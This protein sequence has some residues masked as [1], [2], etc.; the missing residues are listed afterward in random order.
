MNLNDYIKIVELTERIEKSER[1]LNFII[2]HPFRFLARSIFYPLINIKK[3]I[4]NLKNR[5]DIY[6]RTR[7]MPVTEKYETKNFFSIESI[8]DRIYK[9]EI[10]NNGQEVENFKVEFKT[11]NK[12][13]IFVHAYYEDEAVEII[14]NISKFIDYDIVVST[15]FDSIAELFERNMDNDRL[16]VVKFPNHGRDIFPFLISIKLVD[17][18]RYA[19]FIKIHTKRSE[20]LNDK[21]D[22]FKRNIRLLVGNKSISD[23]LL[24]TVVP[25]TCT[26]VGVEKFPIQD[27]LENNMPWLSHLVGSKVESVKSYFIPGTMF[28]GT[29]SFLKLLDEMNLHLYKFEEENSQLDGCCIHSLERYFGHLTRVNKGECLTIEELADKEQLL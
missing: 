16:V 8:S 4:I 1:D 14:D 18:D 24:S 28:F 25:E 2:N 27:H 20:H 6:S 7:P 15:P 26:L 9:L 23:R 12:K 21:G 10:A 13:I 29:R 22:W 5:S 19:C 17:L 3:R 11:G